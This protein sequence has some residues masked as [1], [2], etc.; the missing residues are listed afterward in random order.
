MRI[1]VREFEYGA[2]IPR[3]HTCDGGDVNPEITISD[4][5]EHAQD[6][7]LIVSDPDASGGAVFTHWIMWNIPFEH[8]DAVVPANVGV[9][10]AIQGT[11][12]AGQL[13][14]MGPCPGNGKAHRYFF[15]VYALSRT[16]SLSQTATA[17]QL[18][19]AIQPFVIAQAE[20]MGTYQRLSTP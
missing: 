15:I 19:K 1:R 3:L 7:V 9:D 12:S 18:H 6:I 4:I 5:P 11:T 8:G 10:F 14:Y 20:Y 17:E 2:E 13:G 16:I